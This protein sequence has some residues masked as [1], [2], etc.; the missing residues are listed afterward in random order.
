MGVVEVGIYSFE[1]GERIGTESF[2][3][4]PVKG[5]LIQVNVK[6]DGKFYK[7]KYVVWARHTFIHSYWPKLYVTD[8]LAGEWMK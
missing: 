5:E 3:R 8:V 1:T 4:V 7:V 2:V 6:R